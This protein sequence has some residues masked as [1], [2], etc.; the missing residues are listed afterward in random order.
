LDDVL[1]VK[2]VVLE[3]LNNKK[4][5]LGQKLFILNVYLDNLEQ[6]GRFIWFQL[7]I[8]IRNTKNGFNKRFSLDI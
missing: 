1:S 6:F 2:P 5:S 7:E 4:S 3:F 8:L